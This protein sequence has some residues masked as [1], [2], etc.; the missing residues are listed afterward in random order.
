[1]NPEELMTPLEAHGE[2]KHAIGRFIVNFA[3]CELWVSAWARQCF[4]AAEGVKIVKNR[5]EQRAKLVRAKLLSEDTGLDEPTTCAAF[6]DLLRLAHFRNLIAHNPPI[7]SILA[8]PDTSQEVRTQVRL[9]SMRD[10]RIET[11]L[12]EIIAKG[13]EAGYLAGRM[14][15]MQAQML[16]WNS[17][18][19]RWPL[20]GDKPD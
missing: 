9:I 14:L 17:F 4:P 13:T 12:A 7:L 18:G 20:D 11:T 10:E 8:G 16:S 1:M 3:E 5:L 19:A 2:W 15:N 6:D